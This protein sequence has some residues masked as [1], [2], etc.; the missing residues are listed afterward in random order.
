MC[1]VNLYRCTSR[2]RVKNFVRVCGLQACIRGFSDLDLYARTGDDGGNEDVKGSCLW[3]LELSG[4][5]AKM[6]P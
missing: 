3:L 5:M 4:K 6:V 2:Y 1:L